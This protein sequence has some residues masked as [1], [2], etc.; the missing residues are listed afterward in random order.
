MIYTRFRW[1]FQVRTGGKSR[2]LTSGGASDSNQSPDP[3]KHTQLSA[4]P[5]TQ[6]R[7]LD[8]SASGEASERKKLSKITI[9]I[10]SSNIYKQ[11]WANLDEDDP[12]SVSLVCANKDDYMLKQDL[13]VMCGSVGLGDQGLLISCVQC[14]QCYHPYCA[15]VKASLK[16]IITF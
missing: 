11:L 12:K 4:T 3:T 16:R 2:G 6:R 5:R 1:Y 9:K 15:D 14:G 10:D 13:C 7:A 8:A